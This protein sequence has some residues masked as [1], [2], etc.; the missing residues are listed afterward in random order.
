M[1]DNEK[2][3]EINTKKYTCTVSFSPEHLA[4]WKASQLLDEEIERRVRA[5]AEKKTK[6]IG[7]LIMGKVKDES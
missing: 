5:W 4:I 2:V 6:E 1:T 7:N 3:I